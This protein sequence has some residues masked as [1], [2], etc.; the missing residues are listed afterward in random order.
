MTV[1]RCSSHHDDFLQQIPDPDTIR[2]WLAQSIQR[3]DLLRSLLRV[4]IR[5]SKYPESMS[6]PANAVAEDVAQL[7]PVAQE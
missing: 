1:P 6:S 5:K 2:L 7:G 4:A 3:V